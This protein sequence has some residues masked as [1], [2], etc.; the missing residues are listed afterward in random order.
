M[1]KNSLDYLV[2]AGA[3]RAGFMC[4]IALCLAIASTISGCA[5]PDLPFEDMKRSLEHP[6][7]WTSTNDAEFDTGEY[8]SLVLEFTT[9]SDPDEACEEIL[10]SLASWGVDGSELESLGPVNLC[11]YSGN[12]ADAFPSVDIVFARVYM[13]RDSTDG[14]LNIEISA[15]VDR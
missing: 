4:Q 6:A 1:S 15:Q 8:Y 2:S 14:V 9:M 10:A 7:S 3:P 13:Q 12:E 5:N 11:A